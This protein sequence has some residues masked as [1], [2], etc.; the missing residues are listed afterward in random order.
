MK[1]PK[2]SKK[3][4]LKTFTQNE[5][6]RIL[7]NNIP[8]IEEVYFKINPY[9]SFYI[10]KPNMPYIEGF[11]KE[12]FKGHDQPATTQRVRYVGY[13]T[14]HAKEKTAKPSS[15]MGTN[16]GNLDQKEISRNCVQIVFKTDNYDPHGRPLLL[17]ECQ[18]A[19]EK[20]Q[21]RFYEMLFLHKGGKDRFLAFPNDIDTTHKNKIIQSLKRGILSMNLAIGVE[22]VDKIT[23][24]LLINESPIPDLKFDIINTHLSEDAKMTKQEVEGE[25]ASGAL[26]GNAPDVNAKR[27]E[28]ETTKLTIRL[29]EIFKDLYYVFRGKDPDS[30]EIFFNC[31]FDPLAKLEAKNQAMTQEKKQPDDLEVRKQ[32]L[33][34]K[35]FEFRSKKVE[36]KQE[37]KDQEESTNHAITD[38]YVIFKGNMFVAGPIYYLDRKD[39]TKPAYRVFTGDEIKRVTERDIRTGY[40]NFDHLTTNFKTTN[41]MLEGIGFFKILGYDPNL[42]QDIS[43]YYIREKYSRLLENPDVIRLSPEIFI[44]KEE[45]G[46]K[47]IYVP[48]CAVMR[49]ATTRAEQ[50][51]LKTEAVRISAMEAERLI[52][53]YNKRV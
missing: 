46:S 31:E 11:N 49:N 53:Q 28:K 41:A 32:E 16:G 50:S 34:E 3:A 36:S 44:D 13:L 5:E 21:L 47:R 14:Q 15:I 20:L 19:L 43:L 2:D 10:R 37:K 7:G 39:S 45:D 52:K 30:Y 42:R 26:G 40:L 23:E 51:G 33:R 48:Q 4:I 1:D 25:A 18:T 6:H 22:N 17:R 29:K 12:K 9:A 27:D 38:K 8:Q 24:Q 35:D